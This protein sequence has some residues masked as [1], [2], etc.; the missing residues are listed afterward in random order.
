LIKFVAIFIFFTLSFILSANEINPFQKDLDFKDGIVHYSVTGSING[1]KTMYIKDYGKRRVIYTNTQ[2]KFMRKNTDSD[3]IEYIT[4]K[5]TYEIDLKKRTTTKLPN[6]NYLLFKK[7]NKLVKKKRKIIEKN[8]NKKFKKDKINILGYNC[9]ITSINGILTYK[10]TNKN[11]ILKTQTSILGFNKTVLATKIEKKPIDTDIFTL[12]KNL[13]I[14]NSS[15]KLKKLNK[16]AND[17]ISA[18]L[19]KKDK[20]K[21]DYKTNNS[22]ED[23]HTL[24]QQS[25][26]ILGQL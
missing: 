4:S 20:I 7:Y 6:L 11:L 8:L 22:T 19:N 1:S 3:K 10:A 17:I 2:N 14:I 9:N 21:D 13:E 16:K 15:D 24:I 25:A 26:N 23:F 18:L 12:P 5:W